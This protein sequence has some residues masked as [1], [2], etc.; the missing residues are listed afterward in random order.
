MTRGR[1]P[2][3]L[4]DTLAQHRER[5]RVAVALTTLDQDLSRILEPAAAPP[6]ARL[7]RIAR[8]AEAGVPVEVRLEPLI[9]DLTDTRE[10]I[11]PLFAALARRRRFASGR[12][13]PVPARS[14]VR[15][16]EGCTS[17]ARVHREARGR[18]QR[19]TL[20]LSWHL[21]LDTA[22][23]ARRPPGRPG[24][25]LRV[26]R[27]TWAA[28]RNRRDPE[29]RPAPS[30]GHGAVRRA[31][32]VGSSPPHEEKRNGCEARLARHDARDRVVLPRA[33]LVRC[34]LLELVH[35]GGALSASSSR[36][37]IRFVRKLLSKRTDPRRPTRRLRLASALSPGGISK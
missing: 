31:Q 13:L 10:N 21:G 17:P 7:G 28:R 20:V 18:L 2:L 36:T 19:R 6:W 14:H 1:I 34:E 12:A 25:A 16:A 3:D 11:R 27:G 37:E 5:V 9:P 32:P 22:S 8:L 33:S 4:I 26:G 29:S 15:H 30:P 35:Q 24:E 23:A